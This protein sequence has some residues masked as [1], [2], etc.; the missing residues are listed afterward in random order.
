[1]Q[2]PCLVILAAGMGSRFGGLKQITAVD[3]HGH[4]IIDFSLYDAY[5][6]GFRKVVFVIKHAI[7]ADFRA[8]VADLLPEK[9]LRR[10]KNPYPKTCSPQFARQ[11]RLLAER[12]VSDGDAPIFRVVDRDRM[13]ERKATWRRLAAKHQNSW[14]SMYRS[15]SK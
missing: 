8:A 13:L 3:D 5:R 12:L 9:L 14:G 4:A 1:M 6:A 10:K 15:K 7:E 11:M 2:E